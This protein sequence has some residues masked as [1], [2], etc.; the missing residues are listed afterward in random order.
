MLLMGGCD[1]ISTPAPPPTAA[2]LEMIETAQSITQTAVYI[3]QN[4]PPAGFDKSVSFPQI[5]LNLTNQPSY[6]YTFSLTFDGVFSGTQDKAQGSINAE[7]YSDEVGSTRR[8]ILKASGSAFGLT[9]DRNVEAVRIGNTYYLV[10]TNKVCSKP[11][12]VQNRKVAD[13]VANSFIGGVKNAVPTQ[14]HQTSKNGIESWE[15]TFLPDDI[16]PPALTLSQGGTMTIA[17][18]DLWVAPALKV[19]YT[20]SLTLNV[21]DALLQGDR[22]LTGRIQ[23]DYQ[24]IDS[25][26]S[27]NISIPNGC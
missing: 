4:A 11:T 20:Y 2:S 17:S 18:G 23:A 13:L 24:L 6:H 22:Q 3:T 1:L 21:E 15:Y 16:I 10:D 19:V 9:A 14:T 12:D 5:D 7:V 25:G 8:V 27:Y 26:T